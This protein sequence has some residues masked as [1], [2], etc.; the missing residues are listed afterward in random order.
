MK[1]SA[2]KIAAKIP[3]AS[4]PA[5]ELLIQTIAK[6]D[7]SAFGI[8]IGVVFGTGIFFATNFL[9][10][11]GGERI[12]PTLTLLNQY[13]YGYSVTFTGSLVGLFYGFAAGFALGWLMAFVRNFLIIIYLHIA[14]F[15][16]RIV[17]VNNF[18][19]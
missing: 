11:K 19:D 14:K 3:A 17:A 15:K 13:F 2:P 5:D 1:V 6:I 7:R 16:G 8:A 18:I 9:I 10:L 4:A 12:G